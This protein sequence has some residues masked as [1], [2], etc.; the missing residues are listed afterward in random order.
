MPENIYQAQP[1]DTGFVEE[2]EEADVVAERPKTETDLFIDRMTGMTP[3]QERDMFGDVDSLVDPGGTPELDDLFSV[4][5]EDIMGKPPKP[6]RRRYRLTS[7]GRAAIR[8]NPNFTSLGG[9]R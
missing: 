7:R 4:T 8:A 9:M 5:R 1:E 2:V 6:K 3:E